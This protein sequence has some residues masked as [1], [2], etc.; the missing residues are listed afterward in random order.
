MAS[1]L[2][3]VGPTCVDQLQHVLWGQQ[4]RILLTLGERVIYQVRN[5]PEHRCALSCPQV[6][7]VLLTNHAEGLVRERA[8]QRPR[9]QHLRAVVGHSHRTPVTL[10]RFLLFPKLPL[11]IVAQVG[12]QTHGFDGRRELGAEVVREVRR[13]LGV[14]DL[15]RGHRHPY[16]ASLRHFG[17][18]HSTKATPNARGGRKSVRRKRH[19]GMYRRGL[20]APRHRH[21]HRRCGRV[22]R[23]GYA[24]HHLFNWS[25]VE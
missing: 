10:L 25:T 15:L 17:A 3:A 8:K 1:R 5:P 11:D 20:A 9:H 21:R 6:R 12:G 18:C 22:P 2:S 24:V 13:R 23:Y 7:R 14:L 16:D 4:G 19:S